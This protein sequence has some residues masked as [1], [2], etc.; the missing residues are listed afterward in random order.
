MALLEVPADRARD[1][2]KTSIEELS[3]DADVRLRSITNV[4]ADHGEPSTVVRNRGP[5]GTTA[6]AGEEPM[7]LTVVPT[8]D[9]SANV[10]LEIDFALD[11][12]VGGNEPRWAARKVV[13]TQDQTSILVAIPPTPG[14]SA[15]ALVAV[16]TPYII[17][18]PTA[19]QRLFECKKAARARR[20]SGT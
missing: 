10:K 7:Q 14:Q 18:G 2:E 17:R 8:V 11:M 20:V 5:F 12:S 1:A 6:L 13:V 16:V 3:R 15:S 4:L 19:L 9:V